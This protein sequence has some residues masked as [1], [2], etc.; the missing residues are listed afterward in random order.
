MASPP[1]AVAVNA[2]ALT[3]IMVKPFAGAGGFAELLKDKRF[4]AVVV[5]PGNGVGA[6]TR[7]MAAVSLARSGAVVLDADALTSFAE[8]PNALYVLL[9]EPA[10]LTP[11]DGRIRAHLSRTA[12][13]IAD[14]H[15]SGAHGRGGGALHGVAERAGHRDCGARRPGRDLDQCAGDIG[16]RRFR[17][18]SF[19]PDRRFNGAGIRIL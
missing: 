19:G 13:P 4:N 14:A 7:D 18:C 8:D 2:A 6:A 1:D 17:G 10:V 16:D 11:H 12:G 9:R 3:A 15:R 5:G